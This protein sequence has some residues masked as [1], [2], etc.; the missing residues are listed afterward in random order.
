MTYFNSED[1]RVFPC[2]YRGFKPTESAEA[3]DAAPHVWNADASLTTEYNLT[4]MFSHLLGQQSFIVSS[5]EKTT[6]ENAD[7][8]CVIN[9]Y[10]FEIDRKAFFKAYAAEVYA[11]DVSDAVAAAYWINTL[12]GERKGCLCVR[13][14]PNF[15]TNDPAFNLTSLITVDSNQTSEGYLLDNEAGKF[16]GCEKVVLKY[17]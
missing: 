14:L 17:D 11:A 16:T 12:R 5:P 4:H 15:D 2:A 1:I 13:V 10:Y 8:K 6:D 7:F 3:L 9:G